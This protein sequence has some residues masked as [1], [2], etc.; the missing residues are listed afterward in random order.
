MLG[1]RLNFETYVKNVREKTTKCS[2]KTTDI[3]LGADGHGLTKFD[4]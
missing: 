2:L 1:C 4:I 3:S